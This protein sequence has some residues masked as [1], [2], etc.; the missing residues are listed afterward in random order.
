MEEITKNNDDLKLVSITNDNKLKEMIQNYEKKWDKK[1]RDANALYK[2]LYKKI[3]SKL[4]E[5]KILAQKLLPKLRNY[6]GRKLYFNQKFP[7]GHVPKQSDDEKKN[8]A[9]GKVMVVKEKEVKVEYDKYG[10]KKQR[11]YF[12]VKKYHI[13]KGFYNIED[14]QVTARAIVF[15]IFCLSYMDSFFEGSQSIQNQFIPNDMYCSWCELDVGAGMNQILDFD[16]GVVKEDA[17]I[18]IRR[19]IHF[20]QEL[21]KDML[22]K[23]NVGYD[24]DDCKE[25]LEFQRLVSCGVIDF[26]IGTVLLQHS[27]VSPKTLLFDYNQ[28][29]GRN[30]EP[31]LELITFDFLRFKR[32]ICYGSDYKQV[33]NNQVALSAPHTFCCE[34]FVFLGHNKRTVSTTKHDVRYFSLIFLDCL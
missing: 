16:F 9:I 32:G 10:R 18:D 6:T 5:L 12:R 14:D 26:F 13:I 7:D 15:Y 21:A 2:S 33:L 27:F 30:G 8:I 34:F 22:E 17:K 1:S 31:L 23:V 11:V 20:D 19:K 28:I 4:S 24:A 3:N 25:A 29:K